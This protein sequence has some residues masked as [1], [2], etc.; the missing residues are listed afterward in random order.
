[1]QTKKYHDDY[2]LAY[3]QAEYY[4][5]AASGEQ[6]R[7]ANA[8]P[9]SGQRPLS[10]GAHSPQGASPASGQFSVPPH[11]HKGGQYK[12]QGVPPGA[13]PYTQKPRAQQPAGSNAEPFLLYPAQEQRAASR[14]KSGY[15]PQQNE[16]SP[17]KSN[18]EHPHSQGLYRRGQQGTM[19]A[20]NSH[21]QRREASAHFSTQPE[22]SPSRT[23]YK[24]GQQG[25]TAH[26]A[27]S[28][29]QG[30]PVQCGLITEALAHHGHY[31]VEQATPPAVAPGRPQADALPA[32]RRNAVPPNAFNRQS[33]V[34][35]TAPDFYRWN[36]EAKQ[37]ANQGKRLPPKAEASS[38]NRVPLPQKEAEEDIYISAELWKH[39]TEL[40]LRGNADALPPKAPQKRAQA[41]DEV[42][43]KPMQKRKFA[44][45]L[46]NLLFVLVIAS[47]LLVAL[48]AGQKGGPRSIFG[49]SYYTVL[50]PSMQSEIPRGSLII[51]KEVSPGTI[52]IGDDITYMR[53]EGSAITH[54]VINIYENYN[55]TGMRGF[56][57]QGIENPTPD[58]KIVY[59]NNV[60]GVVATKIP[61]LG[62]VFYYIGQRIW[63]VLLIM[64][65]IFAL[66]FTLPIWLKKEDEAPDNKEPKKNAGKTHKK[67]SKQSKQDKKVVYRQQPY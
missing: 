29:A 56:Q 28:S 25:M 8:P 24:K 39:N 52:Q 16:S 66:S 4:S 55:G 11:S 15:P 20:A 45:V 12:R 40:P 33:Q 27:Y 17:Y 60:I 59:A 26:G 10:S 9:A 6:R 57:T 49:Y 43:E 48:A 38:R 61:G 41:K 53:E 21:Q 67:K 44:N 36:E 23:V 62:N 1:M 3:G 18:P 58:D 5:N 35:P 14:S 54:R 37:A 2:P 47:L 51:V 19:V 65:L 42:L 32:S 13:A 22:G 30:A 7:A 46:S 63:Q 64:G 34:R 50:T 31:R